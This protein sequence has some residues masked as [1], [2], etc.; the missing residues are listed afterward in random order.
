MQPLHIREG[1]LENA[2]LVRSLCGEYIC[3]R[4][5]VSRSDAEYTV[6]LC[7]KC[8]AELRRIEAKRR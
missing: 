5:A 1:L 4:K 8:R 2:V 7:P 3:F 6:Q